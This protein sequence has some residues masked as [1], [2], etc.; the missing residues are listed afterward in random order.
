MGQKRRRPVDMALLRVPL[1]PAASAARKWT[2]RM[3]RLNFREPAGGSSWRMLFSA[4]DSG[5]PGTSGAISQPTS[6]DRS[7]FTAET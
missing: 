4:C 1:A 2:A 3:A 7:S 5:P 6:R